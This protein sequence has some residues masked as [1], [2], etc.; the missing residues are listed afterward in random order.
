MD[1][2]T[3]ELVAIAASLTAN[4][5]TCLEYHLAKARQ[6]GADDREVQESINIARIVRKVVAEKTDAFLSVVSSNDAA[7]PELPSKSC[8][9][10]G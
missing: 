2:R 8:G 6:L 9:E 10:L 3:K 5:Q 1:A 7:K 4:C